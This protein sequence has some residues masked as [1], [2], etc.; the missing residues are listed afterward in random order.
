[1]DSAIEITAVLFN[2]AYVVLAARK[3]IWC[4]PMG[5]IGSALSVVLFYK[6]GLVAE[7]A[8]FVYYVLMG[9]YG[10]VQWNKNI[11]G[12]TDLPIIQKT[13]SFHIL[14]MILGYACTAL[15]YLVLKNFTDAQMP[16]LDS[17]TTVFSFIATW[18]VARR[19]LE[20]WIYW[21]AI[22]ALTVYLY[23][24]RDLEIYAGL[25]LVYT[26]MAIYG[27]GVWRRQFQKQGF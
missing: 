6:S 7:S 2:I 4:W 23:I 12:D 24:S 11:E 27:Y 21:I 15:L 9:I 5:I 14:V 13:F 20:N 16:L 26:F 19:L 22:D 3:S 10:W 25:S 1:M 8:L 17:F 18:M